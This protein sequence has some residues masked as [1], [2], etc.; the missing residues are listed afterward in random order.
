MGARNG[1]L[2]GHRRP[3]AVAAVA[4]KFRR[5]GPP[6]V[7]NGGGELRCSLEEA[8]R[9]HGALEI[10]VERLRPRRAPW[11]PW[12]TASASGQSR[13]ERPYRRRAQ[14]EA[15][16][17]GKASSA[18][19]PDRR[20]RRI[21][22]SSAVCTGGAEHKAPRYA[23]GMGKGPRSREG[24]PRE[25]ASRPGSRGGRTRRARTQERE[26]AARRRVPASPDAVY[27]GLTAIISKI[28]N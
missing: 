21:A 10:V 17:R 23:R 1:R 15:R 6:A 22:E 25:G 20:G 18:D 3:T 13:E 27:P 14:G 26:S 7:A 8:L 12:R 9:C 2:G 5:G 28:L 16:P 4:G 11:R 19:A 24:A